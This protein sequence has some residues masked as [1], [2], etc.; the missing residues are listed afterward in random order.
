MEFSIETVA[1]GRCTKRLFETLYN[2][3]DNFV[4]LL[5]DTWFRIDKTLS[6]FTFWAPVC[7]RE[8][9]KAATHF[10]VLFYLLRSEFLTGCVRKDQ[11]KFIHQLQSFTNS[12]YVVQ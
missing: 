2:F 1:H 9:Q 5:S 6:V 12:H 3:L 10:V 8:L 4:M 11:L 7:V